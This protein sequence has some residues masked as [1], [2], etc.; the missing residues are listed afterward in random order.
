MESWTGWPSRSLKEVSCLYTPDGRSSPTGWTASWKGEVLT[1]DM[2]E[3]KIVEANISAKERRRWYQWIHTEKREMVGHVSWSDKNGFHLDVDE[4]TVHTQACQPTSKRVD[5]NMMHTHPAYCY[6]VN[7][8]VFGWPS[9]MDLDTLKKNH[10]PF[11]AV[12]SKEGMY[13]IYQTMCPH[14]TVLD[15]PSVSSDVASIWDYLWKIGSETSFHI[16]FIPIN[17]IWTGKFHWFVHR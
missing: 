5:N 8:S 16:F 12:L 4:S 2:S 1:F 9:G 11:H 14:D 7:Q 17:V 10:I 13:H 15:I 6:R 3:Y